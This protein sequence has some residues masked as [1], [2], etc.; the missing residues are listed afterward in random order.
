ME[1]APCLRLRSLCLRVSVFHPFKA[2]QMRVS[3]AILR[4][5][6]PPMPRLRLLALV[7]LLGA[8]PPPAP[9]PAAEDAVAQAKAFLPASCAASKPTCADAT[10][11]LNDYLALLDDALRCMGPK[12][13]L[14][15]V[16][17]IFARDR[18]LD[19]REH[20]LPS[21]ARS[22]GDKRP[23]LRLSLFVI[24]AAGMALEAADPKAKPPAYSNAEVE[25]GKI[26]ERACSLG[27]ADLCSEGRSQLQC[28]KAVDS[29]SAACEAKACLYPEQERLA[30]AA[31]ACTRSYFHFSG[32][33]VQET[34]AM[35]GMLVPSRARLARVLGRTSEAKLAELESAGAS[36]SAGLDAL[37]K[38]SGAD[39]PGRYA[40][41]KASQEGAMKL[42]R[43]ASISADRTQLLLG[44]DPDMK[45][46]AGINRAAASLASARGR[47]AAINTARGL[48]ISKDAA[49]VVQSVMA[50][51]GNA[52]LGMAALGGLP[53]ARLKGKT[54]DR[55]P[56]PLAISARPDAPPILKASGGYLA[57]IKNLKSKNPL[58]RADAMRRLGLTSLVG[59]PAARAPLVHPQDAGDTC[60]I[61]AQQQILLAHGLLPK[62]DPVKQEQALAREAQARGFYFSSAG[63]PREFQGDLLVDRGLIVT[64]QVGAPLGTLDAAVRR[65]GMII[66]S[67][68]A[69]FLWN[70]NTPEKLGHAVVVT[71]AEIER[72]GGKTLGYYI[73]DSGVS[74]NGAGRFVPIAQFA[75]AWNGHTKSFAEVR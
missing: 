13:K 46:R 18:A 45:R 35:F 72:V 56:V 19:E 4:L 1:T 53:A 22:S 57:H 25:S 38:N 31:E 34:T 33:V 2:L 42:Y 59:D 15:E 66:V 58:V 75:K 16:Q 52:A 43:D 3:G 7:F 24:T 71:G 29:G 27:I 30:I 41:L 10:G 32:R 17:S 49:G 44:G 6:N 50:D 36:L 68:D 12:C 5:E 8:A 63:T 69:R 64:K 65:G 47:L 40:A 21:A 51:A 70:K 20:K 74:A 37:E 26:V 48:N 73:N 9:A 23:F 67:V 14:E 55:R 61:V 11:L 28:A 60:A 54:I 62:E 39:S